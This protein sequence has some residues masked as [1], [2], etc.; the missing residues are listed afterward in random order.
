MIPAIA[1][2]AAPIISSTLSNAMSQPETVLETSKPLSHNNTVYVSSAPLPPAPT[3]IPRPVANNSGSV[4][5]PFQH[6]VTPFTLGTDVFMTTTIPVLPSVA[7]LIKTFRE[8]EL[9]TLAAVAFPTPASMSKPCTLNLCWTPADVTPLQDAILSV[10]GSTSVTLGGF[11]TLASCDYPCDL[12]FVNAFIKHPLP[13][14][15]HPRLSMLASGSSP[16]AESTKTIQCQ[17]IIRGTI[18]LTHPLLVSP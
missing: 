8:A 10:P 16:G 7:Q 14:S 18:R 1:S 12:G 11:H 15:N 5:A 6:H 9:L 13:F 17:L 4:V 2:L 3:P